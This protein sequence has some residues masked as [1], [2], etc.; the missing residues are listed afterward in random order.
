MLLEEWC[1]DDSPDEVVKELPDMEEDRLPKAPLPLPWKA[2]RPKLA[3]PMRPPLV[4]A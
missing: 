1:R 4:A 2:G 3:P